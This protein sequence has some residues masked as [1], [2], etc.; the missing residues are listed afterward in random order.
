MTECDEEYVNDAI[1]NMTLEL[2]GAP[3]L[4]RALFA[5]SWERMVLLAIYAGPTDEWPWRFDDA[6][7]AMIRSR[8]APE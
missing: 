4:E 5:A 6:Y 3:R 2:T 1:D 7:M 8:N